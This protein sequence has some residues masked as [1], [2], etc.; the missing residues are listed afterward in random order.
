M[1]KHYFY[2]NFVF[3][4]EFAILQVLL[5]IQVCIYYFYKNSTS[6]NGEGF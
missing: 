3:K 1:P 5:V 6:I 4:T 2:S